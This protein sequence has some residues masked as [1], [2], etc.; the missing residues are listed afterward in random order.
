[1]VIDWV[2]TP[3][4]LN[5]VIFILFLIS[6][7]DWWLIPPCIT[8]SGN[9]VRSNAVE[10][11]VQSLGLVYNQ[12]NKWRKATQIY[13]REFPCPNACCCQNDHWHAKVVFMQFT[14]ATHDRIKTICARSLWNHLHYPLICMSRY[15]CLSIYLSFLLSWLQKGTTTFVE[16]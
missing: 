4:I 11:R 1:M 13:L 6:Q 3:T 15:V 16:I 9:I 10:A 5:C 7:N 8:V 12:E 14:P 2:V